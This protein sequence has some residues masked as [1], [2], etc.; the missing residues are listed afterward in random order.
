MRTNTA[1]ATKLTPRHQD[2]TVILPDGARRRMSIEPTDIACDYKKITNAPDEFCQ[3]GIVRM[4][5]NA[6]GSYTPVLKTFE[7]WVKLT[8]ATLADI[9]LTNC[10]SYETITRL[11]DCGAIACRYPSPKVRVIDLDTLISWIEQAR[12][13]DYWTPA[14]I[15]AYNK[16]LPLP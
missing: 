9:G 8:Y 5:R 15:H 13:P 2:I 16:G 1:T 11:I 3:Y 7:R 6:D 14:R 4:V 10:I 12:D